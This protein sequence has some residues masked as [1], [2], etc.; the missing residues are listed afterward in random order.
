MFSK[1]LRIFTPLQWAEVILI[2]VI[3]IVT[4]NIGGSVIET[5]QNKF[6]M[7]TKSSLK[8]KTINQENIIKDVTDVNKDLIKSLGIIDKSNTV[9]KDSIVNNF[10]NELKIDTNFQSIKN[11]KNESI[12]KIKE[13]FNKEPVTLENTLE[14]EKQVSTKQITALWTMY[15]TDTDNSKQ[16]ENINHV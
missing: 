2:V 13:T 15:C 3:A 9:S 7:E 14:M 5:I 6:G 8:E 10:K 12:A 11:K 1:I 16:C 4:F